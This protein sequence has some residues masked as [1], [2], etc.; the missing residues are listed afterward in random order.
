MQGNEVALI[1]RPFYI[2]TDP[3]S[4][5]RR[6]RVQVPSFIDIPDVDP[7]SG[8]LA[9]GDAI[10]HSDK[11]A[12]RRRFHGK[13]GRLPGRAVGSLPPQPI[14]LA[15]VGQPPEHDALAVGIRISCEIA[16][17]E[18]APFNGI[19]VSCFCRTVD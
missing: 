10:D 7:A 3:V 13:Y 1:H 5:I 17:L 6:K 9:P 12:A 15:S 14:E 11:A 19:S 18:R 8:T 4:G 2:R 16:V